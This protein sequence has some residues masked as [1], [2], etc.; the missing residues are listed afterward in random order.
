MSARFKQVM[1]DLETMGT[2]P[3]SAIV[4]IGAVFF[5]LPTLETPAPEFGPSFYANV[6]LQSSIDAG[7]KVDGNTVYW[8]LEQ[9]EAARRRL[10][11]K[12]L[13]L[14]Q[15]LHEFRYFWEGYEPQPDSPGSYVRFQEQHDMSTQYLWAHGLDFDVGILRTA[16]AQIH[17]PHPWKYN[18]VNDDRTLYRN[19][20]EPPWA[21]LRGELE[22]VE[23]N[24]LYDAQLQAL[25]VIWAQ[26]QLNIQRW[27]SESWDKAAGAQNWRQVQENTPL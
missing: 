7:L 4:A 9:D 12:R 20:G 23:H 15:A 24:A 17:R 11:D 18:R 1:V 16:Y 5:N 14:E 10:L 26:N 25:G 19:T 13:G 6:D 3:D 8:W 27:K 2:R 22:G 21:E